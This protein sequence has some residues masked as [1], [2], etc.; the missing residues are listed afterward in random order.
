MKWHDVL[1]ESESPDSFK[2][3]YLRCGFMFFRLLTLDLPS[4]LCSINHRIPFPD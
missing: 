2:E 1:K 4:D 3:K